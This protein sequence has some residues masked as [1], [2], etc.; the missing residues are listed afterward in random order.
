MHKTNNDLDFP[1]K[2]WIVFLS[3]LLIY[4]SIV[5]V[6]FRATHGNP[7]LMRKKKAGE[8]A[9]NEKERLLQIAPKKNR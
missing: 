3:V 8:G 9:R 1:P 2:A 7:Q 4:T 6:I 5:T